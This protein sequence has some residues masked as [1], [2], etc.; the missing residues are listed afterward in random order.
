MQNSFNE[1]KT[2][3][4]HKSIGGYHGAKIRRYQD[5]IEYGISNEIKNIIQKI[6]NGSDD[7]SKSHIINMLNVGFLKFNNKSILKL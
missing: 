4:H 7:F 1:A 2:S 5:L 6:Q 3:F